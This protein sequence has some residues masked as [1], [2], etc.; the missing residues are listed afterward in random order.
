[1]IWTCPNC[2]HSIRMARV[3]LPVYCACKFVD[4]TQDNLRSEG[5]GDTIAKITTAIGIKPCGGC[6]ERQAKLNAAV[7]YAQPLPGPAATP[8]A[9]SAPTS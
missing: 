4:R 6:K 3:V 1:M 7:P 8:A 5:L 9:D 2:G